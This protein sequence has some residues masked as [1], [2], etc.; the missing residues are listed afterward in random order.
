MKR[1]V[2]HIAPKCALCEMRVIAALLALI[3][4]RDRWGSWGWD[5]GRV[6][7]ERF[8]TTW[9]RVPWSAHVYI[10]FPSRVRNPALH[11]ATLVHEEY[12]V[13]QMRTTWGWVKTV[14]LYTVLPLPVFLSGRWLVERGAFLIDIKAGAKTVDEAVDFLHRH[15]L[16]PWPRS[17]MR[18]WFLDHV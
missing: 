14:L 5:R 2:T 12:H 17:W 15:Y 1:E 4:R 11:P 9:K 6:F 7:M 10:L 18:R 3:P 8:W 13:R 16:R